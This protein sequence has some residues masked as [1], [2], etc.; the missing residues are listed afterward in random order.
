LIGRTALRVMGAHSL[1]TGV[2]QTW[3]KSILDVNAPCHGR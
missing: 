1:P 2:A 3:Y